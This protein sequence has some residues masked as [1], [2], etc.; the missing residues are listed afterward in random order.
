MTDK[1][2]LIF[3]FRAEDKEFKVGSGQAFD[4]TEKPDGLDASEYTVDIENYTFMDGGRVKRRRIEPR[5]IAFTFKARMNVDI[6]T[7]R[8]EVLSFFNPKSTGILEVNYCGQRRCIPYEVQSKKDNQERLLSRLAFHVELIAPDPDWRELEAAE[9]VVSTWTGGWGWPF[10]FPFTMRQPG[11][12][13]I[14]I[15]NDGDFD[16]PCLITFKGPAVNPKII[17]EP[18]GKFIKLNTTLADTDTLYIGNLNR[19]ANTT[20]AIVDASG[21]VSDAYSLIDPASR[22][23]EIVRGTNTIAYTTDQA[24]TLPQIVFVSYIERFDY[25]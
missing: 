24:Q 14:T 12:T 25:V 9:N 10:V 23:F 6:P 15:D 1:P 11:E 16:S 21:T 4:F 7:A 18:S 2:T 5:P 17:H 20:I 13:S 3:T 19:E 22:P 8:S